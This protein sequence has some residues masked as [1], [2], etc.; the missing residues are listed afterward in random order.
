M[1]C[2]VGDAV[3]T[4]GNL[5][6]HNPVIATVI[7]AVTL[8]VMPVI[9]GLELGA[10]LM[11]DDSQYGTVGKPELNDK[12]KPYPS[13][14]PAGEQDAIALAPDYYQTFADVLSM[15]SNVDKHDS[16]SPLATALGKAG[17]ELQNAV[18]LGHDQLQ[19]LL[20]MDV[21][22]G[23]TNDAFVHNFNT[24]MTEL[25]KWAGRLSLLA[26]CIDGYYATMRNSKANVDAAKSAYEEAVNS[27]SDHTNDINNVYNDHAKKIMAIYEG[28]IKDV[29]SHHPKINAADPP[30]ANPNVNGPANIGGGGPTGL[31]GGGG[32]PKV[33][34]PSS[35]LGKNNPLNTTNTPNK[36]NTPKIPTDA[37]NALNNAA[38]KGAQQA[39]NAAQQAGNAAQQAL[40]KALSGAQ[41]GTPKVPEGVLGLGPKGLGGVGKGG[42]AGGGRGG[43]GGAR[44]TTP[45]PTTNSTAASK[46]PGAAAAKV[47]RAGVSGS[48]GAGAGAPAAGNRSGGSEKLHKANK[49]LRTM[50]NG[51]EVMGEAD[52]VVSVL[53]DEPQEAP[54]AKAT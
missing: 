9:G 6:D 10:W 30:Q 14:L 43:G 12:F 20:S 16:Q 33:P 46:A 13:D 25:G 51:Q 45:R 35:L 5:I 24:G 21:L 47:S 36:T 52:A 48:G 31:G 27:Y 42:G 8:P 53:G 28:N 41:N 18:H 29:A 3:G 38:Q 40:G 37:L 1:G 4:V 26:T 2:I 34:T 39:G 19:S 17:Q 32:T 49:A 54:P 15:W 23:S 50:R 11:H 44:A 22:K 7:G